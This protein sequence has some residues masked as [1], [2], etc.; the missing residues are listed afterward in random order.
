MTEL[1]DIAKAVAA[2][3]FMIG[4]EK[5]SVSFATP[6]RMSDE[7]RQGFRELTAAGLVTRRV[8]PSCY[9]LEYVATLEVCDLG[10]E[11]AK[12]TPKEDWPSFPITYENPKKWL[13]VGRA[14][15][16]K[17]FANENSIAGQYFRTVPP[18]SITRGH[19]LEGLEGQVRDPETELRLAVLPG[20]GWH[21]QPETLDR[22]EARGFIAETEF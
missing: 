6:T 15:V 8:L 11:F 3:F 7:L 2:A 13:L 19:A 5:T 16:A 18:D 14:V 12:V 21:P 9:G 17:K 4:S 20:M 10:W 1:S 22:I